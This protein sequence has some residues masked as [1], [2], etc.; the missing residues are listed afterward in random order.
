MVASPAFSR[1]AAFS[2]EDVV[3]GIA[4]ERL[5]KPSQQILCRVLVQGY[6]LLGC[7]CLATAHD[8]IHN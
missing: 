4:I 6:S 2:R 1:P 7:L 8:L 3:I 5:L